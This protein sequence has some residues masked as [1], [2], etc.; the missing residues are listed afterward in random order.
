M[1]RAPCATS[2]TSRI[3]ALPRAVDDGIRGA[4]PS[5]MRSR[6]PP[7]SAVAPLAND[8][9]PSALSRGFAA[10]T[11]SIGKSTSPRRAPTTASA[12][13]T[14]PR[15]IRRAR[16]PAAGPGRAPR[17]RSR[18]PAAKLLHA[19]SPSPEGRS[20]TGVI[21]PTRALRDAMLGGIR[22]RLVGGWTASR[23]RY[24]MRLLGRIGLSDRRA[25]S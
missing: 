4:G 22:T 15:T 6:Q 19:R 10:M 25:S 5:Y 20:A 9:H 8:W 2:R 1:E 14:P 11:A 24:E 16:R 13:A 21:A 3:I 23:P 12:M 17:L 18:Y 7:G